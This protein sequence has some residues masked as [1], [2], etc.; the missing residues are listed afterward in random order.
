MCKNNNSCC[1]KK[2]K[3]LWN[4]NNSCCFT[5]QVVGCF[6]SICIYQIVFVIC[7][8]LNKHYYQHTH[9]LCL[10]SCQNT[11][12][13][14][15]VSRKEKWKQALWPIT[16]FI[17]YSQQY[18]WIRQEKSAIWY[19]QDFCIKQ[20]WQHISL[21]WNQQKTQA[22]TNLIS[23][24]SCQKC[25]TKFYKFTTFFL[26]LLS[27]FDKETCFIIVAD[28]FLHLCLYCETSFKILLSFIITTN[29]PIFIIISCSLV[30]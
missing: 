23:T 26:S 22:Q 17:H 29:L 25:T 27:N 24:I 14:R 13:T 1:Y 18:V 28:Y 8:S 9:F 5:T 20:Q 11:S 19:C 15:N 4:E 16:Y 6:L 7:H 10:Y 30:V 3:M 12:L 21:Q 2:K